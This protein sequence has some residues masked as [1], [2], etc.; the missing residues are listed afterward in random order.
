MSCF[1]FLQ[2]IPTSMHQLKW[3]REKNVM[4]TA[5]ISQCVRLAIFVYAVG[6]FSAIRWILNTPM[7]FVAKSMWHVEF[8]V[9]FE[10]QLSCS[11]MCW[12]DVFTCAICSCKQVKHAYFACASNINM[13]H[14]FFKRIPS[15]LP[16]TE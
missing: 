2:S 7:R 5:L 9:L 13:R 1:F 12:I 16:M 10:N 4:V 11:V 14:T 3:T 15:Y 8:V 6:S